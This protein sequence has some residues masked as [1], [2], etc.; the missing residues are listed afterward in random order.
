MD[1]KA[2][3]EAAS[4][5]ERISLVRYAEATR[6]LA[7]QRDTVRVTNV[8]KH[9]RPR[10]SPVTKSPVEDETFTDN[11]QAKPSVESAMKEKV[12]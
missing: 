5:G 12:K 8:T 6:V 2:P 7:G 1:V 11:R 9:A 3:R 4:L 10:T